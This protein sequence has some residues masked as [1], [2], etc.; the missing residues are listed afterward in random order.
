MSGQVIGINTA[1]YTPNGGSVGIGFAIPSDLAKPVIEQLKEHGKVERGWLG[2]QVQTV[3]PELANSFG[4]SKAEGALVTEVFHDTPAAKAGLKQGDVILSFDGHPIDKPRDLSIKVA[5]TPAGQSARLILW[6]D[7]SRVPVELTVAK[8]PVNP[9]VAEAEGSGH[10]SA[11]GVEL[12][13][14]TTAE[15]K[16]LG[17]GPKVHGAVVYSIGTSSILADLD[18]QPGDVI[19]AINQKPVE[20]P[21]QAAT[22]INQARKEQGNE[23]NLLILVDRHGV[24]QF[25]AVAIENGSNG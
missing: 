21:E 17:I 10:V 25:V 9:T 18:I 20:T 15:R 14:L 8:M 24:E 1:I 22:L 16:K 4:L 19:E 3:T 2:V 6:R 5:E 23:R 12:G 11:A 7:G 13:P